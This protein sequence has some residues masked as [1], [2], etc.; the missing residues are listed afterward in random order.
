MGRFQGW[1]IA[2]WLMRRWRPHGEDGRREAWVGMRWATAGRLQAGLTELVDFSELGVIKGSLVFEG[3][4]EAVVGVRYYQ[5]RRS[6][7][8]YWTMLVSLSVLMR[9]GLPVRITLT[10]QVCYKGL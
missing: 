2:G 1:V 5:I 9:L 8:G 7:S 6:R 3:L 10:Q 4:M